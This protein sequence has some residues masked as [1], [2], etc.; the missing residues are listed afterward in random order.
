M[1]INLVPL[2]GSVRGRL[3]AT[4]FTDVG[5]DP[6]GALAALP[7]DTLLCLLTDHDVALRFPA[8]AAWLAEHGDGPV[9]RFP[10]ED[11]GVADED[12][13]LALV[14]DLVRRLR[15]GERVVAHCGAGIGRTSLVCGLALVALTGEP[16][17]DALASVRAAR[18]GAGPE[19]PEQRA[20]LERL[21]DVL[22]ARAELDSIG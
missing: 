19:N 11:G 10:I 1:P 5:P 16:L 8:F 18:P 14:D 7:A 20:H 2:P 22:T 12:E 3:Y 17:A 13:M 15:A 6:A 9:W 4:G 21:A